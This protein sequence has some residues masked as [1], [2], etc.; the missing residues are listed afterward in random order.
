ME[1][2]G[3]FVRFSDPVADRVAAFAFLIASLEGVTDKKIKELAYQM[4]ENAAYS[5]HIPKPSAE[6]LR[7]VADNTA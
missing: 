7:M 2:D 1:E 5:I 6:I 4:M 3:L